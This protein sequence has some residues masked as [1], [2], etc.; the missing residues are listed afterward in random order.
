M[1]NV[2]DCLLND[3]EQEFGDGEVASINKLLLYLGLLQ[4]VGLA[5]HNVV[6]QR[7]ESLEVPEKGLGELDS[8]FEPGFARGTHCDEVPAGQLHGR[9]GLHLQLESLEECSAATRLSFEGPVPT[10][11]G[12]KLFPLPEGEALERAL[13]DVE[14]CLRD[15]GRA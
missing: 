3:R 11:L 6:G 13:D 4:F 2:R 14:N 10:C 1:A 12:H 8:S 5:L 15:D 9:E 7:L